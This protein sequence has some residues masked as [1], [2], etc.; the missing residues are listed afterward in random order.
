M[1]IY[2]VYVKLTVRKKGVNDMELKRKINVMCA[3]AGI[4]QA[5][6]AR[7]LGES[8]SNF[9]QKFVKETFKYDDL[10]RIA[11]ATG[12]ELIFITKDGKRI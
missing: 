1:L 7:R 5:E 10:K 8:R 11:Q 9:S 2:W 12:C 6:L 3:Y 4:N